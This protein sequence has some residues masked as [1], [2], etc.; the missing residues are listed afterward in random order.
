MPLWKFEPAA[1]AR[2]DLWQG[3]TIWREVIVEAPSAAFAREYAAE[4]ELSDRAPQIANESLSRR[5]AFHD[6]HAY[7][8]RQLADAEAA[9]LAATA[10]SG[11]PIRRATRLT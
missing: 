8:V 11:S 3:R 4:W 2:D 5:S 1:D 6:H 7:H 9:A 10:D